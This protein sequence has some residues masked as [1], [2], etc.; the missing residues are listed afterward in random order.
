MKALIEGFIKFQKEVFPQRT[1][2]FKYLATTQNPETLFITCSDSRVIPE[3][4]TQQEPGELFVVRNAGNIVPSYG[5][6]PGGVTATVEYAVAILGVK[7]IVICG[8]SDC[9]AMTA[10]SSGKSLDHLPAVAAWMSYA[11]SAKVI[12]A[13][14]IFH[15]DK[16]RV[17]SMVN[18]NVIAQLSNIRTHPSVRLAMEKGNLTL[19]GWVYDIETGCINTLDGKTNKFVPLADFPE[20]HA[21]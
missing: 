4:L 5:P 21:G 7:D 16:E 19:H 2:L 10:V 9:G 20:T 1:D 15:S 14:R 13:A 12:N 3:M 11:E 17:S 6:Q 8:H 18:E